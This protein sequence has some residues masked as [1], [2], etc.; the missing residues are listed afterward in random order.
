MNNKQPAA[1]SI[2]GMTAGFFTLQ[3]SEKIRKTADPVIRIRPFD[4][5]V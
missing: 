4:Y 1:L 3:G 5:Y 2:E